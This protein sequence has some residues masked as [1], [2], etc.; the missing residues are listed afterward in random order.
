MNFQ[1]FEIKTLCRRKCV[2]CVLHCWIYSSP[3]DLYKKTLP[4]LVLRLSSH[5]TNWAIKAGLGWTICLIFF[6]AS[7]VS[8]NLY[9]YTQ[10][11]PLKD[12]KKKGMYIL[13]KVALV[14]IPCPSLPYPHYGKWVPAVLSLSFVQLKGKYCRKPNCRNGGRNVWALALT[15]FWREENG[16]QSFTKSFK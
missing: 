2:C 11:P 5:L 12:P 16:L 13:I 4:A 14:D 7:N 15:G 9:L 3:C 10:E 6:T 8:Y 1:F